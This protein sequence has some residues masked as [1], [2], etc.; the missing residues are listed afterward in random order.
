VSDDCFGG[1][2]DDDFDASCP[3]VLFVVWGLFTI[4]MEGKMMNE[5]GWI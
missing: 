3:F 1:R 4:V 5:D 2:I